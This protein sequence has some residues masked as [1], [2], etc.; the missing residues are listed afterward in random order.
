[1][2]KRTLEASYL[3]KNLGI[4]LSFGK[5]KSLSGNLDANILDVGFSYKFRTVE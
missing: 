3:I 4:Q 5:A 1:M 2:K